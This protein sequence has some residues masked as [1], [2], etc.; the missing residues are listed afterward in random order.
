[1]DE[2]RG[3]PVRRAE[4]GCRDM[5]TISEHRLS[6][7]RQLAASAS[8][9]F[10]LL[11]LPQGHV[12]LDGSG[13]LLA[14]PDARRLAAVGD[15]FEI[16][17]DREPLGDVPMGKYTVL[18]TVTDIEPDRRLEWNVV[19]LGRPRVG[20]VYG[21]LLEPVGGAE[22]VVTNYCDWTAVPEQWRQRV[23]WPVVPPEMLER[24][25]LNLQRI[26]EA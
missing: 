25:L 14:A 17:M 9:I 3:E 1:V 19:A 4:P 6:V 26:V 2:L 22:T 20:H 24:S 16:H 8:R 15:T 10:A 18:N 11:T 23:N 7:S 12:D 21:Y 5:T 13:M